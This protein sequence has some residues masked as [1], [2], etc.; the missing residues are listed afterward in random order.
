[1]PTRTSLWVTPSATGL[2]SMAYVNIMLIILG[3]RALRMW[4]GGTK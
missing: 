2:M 4:A 3:I 1:M